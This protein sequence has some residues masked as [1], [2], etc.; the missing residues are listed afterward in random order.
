MGGIATMINKEG[1]KKDGPR[2]TDNFHV[3]EGGFEFEG[4]IWKST[5]QAYQASKF[6]NG[7]VEFNRI[8]DEPSES[9]SDWQYGMRVWDLGQSGKIRE[10][11]ED[12]KL[13]S[14]LLVN[15]AKF[16]DE[17]MAEE[18]LTT[19]PH[20]LEAAPSTWEWQKWNGL[21]LTYVRNELN[22]D[23]DL[24]PIMEGVAANKTDIGSIT[25][26]LLNPE[27]PLRP[28]S[29]GPKMVEIEK[30]KESVFTYLEKDTK[31]E[32]KASIEWLFEQ[33]LYNF[34]ESGLCRQFSY[35]QM[36]DVLNYI[37]CLNNYGSP[38]DEIVEL[39]RCFALL[40]DDLYHT[41]SE[42]VITT[43]TDE[44]KRI[45]DKLVKHGATDQP[46]YE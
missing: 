32:I 14:M 4:L 26:L 22:R 46:R 39:I 29:L 33:P 40:N 35:G 7:S 9:V 34:K 19:L 37:D 30:I 42:E 27:K 41:R 11:W 43:Q 21:I 2:C 3:V 28:D 10:D 16:R 6:E 20:D 36:S 23:L 45:L 18:L 24:I 17:K 5:E 1:F 31:E 44:I 15:L 13:A 12:R 25:S 38:K 8:Y